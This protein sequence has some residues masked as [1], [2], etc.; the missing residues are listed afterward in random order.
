MNL[1][2]YVTVRLCIHQ[3]RVISSRNREFLCVAGVTIK[4][5]VSTPVFVTIVVC[6]TAISPLMLWCDNFRLAR[7]LG[8]CKDG[9][10]TVYRHSNAQNFLWGRIITVS[11]AIDTNAIRIFSIGKSSLDYFCFFAKVEIHFEICH[12]L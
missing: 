4:R 9:G 10:K 7:Y 3:I 12:W 2:I 1:H 8:Q 5:H 11:L 6:D